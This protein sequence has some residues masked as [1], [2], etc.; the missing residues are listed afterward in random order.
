MVYLCCEDEEMIAKYE[1]LGN[2]LMGI[3]ISKDL[4]ESIA[5]YGEWTFG[6]TDI[7][8]VKSSTVKTTILGFVES[9]IIEEMDEENELSLD[10]DELKHMVKDI[11]D[12]IPSDHY[13]DISR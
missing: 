13:I 6:D 9:G 11:F 12:T 3:G 8:L 2:V 10:E 7:V 5:D 4:I 1:E